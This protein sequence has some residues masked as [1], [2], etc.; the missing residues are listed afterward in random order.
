MTF[1]T[2]PCG[3]KREARERREHFCDLRVCAYFSTEREKCFLT[4]RAEN[5]SLSS[6]TPENRD[7]VIETA[8]AVF[9]LLAEAGS[10]EGLE[11]VPSSH[12]AGEGWATGCGGG[13]GNHKI[14]E[15]GQ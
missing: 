2:T 7:Q 15:R 4:C 3:R 8:G 6:H 9:G 1:R 10:R 12:G 13:G 5:N 14:G 11:M